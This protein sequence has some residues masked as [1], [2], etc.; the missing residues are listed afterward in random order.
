MNPVVV[1]ELGYGQPFVPVILPLVYKESEELFDLLVN[2]LGLT[3]CLWVIG[4][5][6]CHSNP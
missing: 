2:P 6:G 3:V 4:H 1:G 5:G